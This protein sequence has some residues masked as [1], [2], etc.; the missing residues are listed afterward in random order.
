MAARSAGT[1]VYRNRAKAIEVL[2]VHPGGPF[3]Q[4][5]DLGAWS[6]PKGEYADHEDAEATARREFTEE[7]GWTIA[8]EMTPLGDIRQKAGKTVSAFAAEGDFDPATL[9]SNSFEMEWPPRSG[10]VASF[11]EVDRAGWFALADAREKIIEG[12]RPL[13]DRL[14]ALLGG[15]V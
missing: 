7:T 5:R 2:L 1:L 10:R 13:L 4:K 15:G 11:P 14:E 12:Q 6:I 9:A 3:W 8:G